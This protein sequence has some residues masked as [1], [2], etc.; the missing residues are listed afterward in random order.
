MELTNREWWGTIHGM[1]LGALFLLAFAGGLS[2]LYSL[3]PGLLTADG[4]V[5]RTR[6][7][8]IGTASMAVLAWLTVFQRILFV[9]RQLRELSEQTA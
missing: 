6:R 7:L 3:R 1:I 4:I 9:R 5:E 2:G 8:K